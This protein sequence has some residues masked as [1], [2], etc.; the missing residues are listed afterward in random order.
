MTD[1]GM[2][3][4]LEVVVRY[5]PLPALALGLPIAASLERVQSQAVTEALKDPSVVAAQ[6][7][8]LP[9]SRVIWVHAWRLSLRPVLGVLGMAVGSVLSGSLAV[10]VVMTWPGLSHLMIG[11][12]IG[13]DLPLAAGCAGLG[14]AL[15][16]IGLLSA[17]I[18]LASADPTILES[19]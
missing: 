12:L 2:S 15:L 13:Q 8:G 6:S 18:A 11:A 19:T 5:L 10:E 16:S 4:L 1:T 9:A 14:A 17:D 3:G 7:R